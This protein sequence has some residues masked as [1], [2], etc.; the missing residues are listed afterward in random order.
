MGNEDEIPTLPLPPVRCLTKER[1]ASYLGIGVTLLQDL[2]IP[3][4]KHQWISA[5]I[6]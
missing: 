1:A 5:T 4:I 3:F 6:M 2:Q